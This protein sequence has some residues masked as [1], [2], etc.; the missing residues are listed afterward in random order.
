MRRQ[1]LPALRM[2]VVLTIAL[3]IG[4]PLVVLGVSQLAFHDKANGSLVT[5]ADGH[6]VGSSL[7]GQTFTGDR[8]FQGRPSA[9][10]ITASGSTD[11]DGQPGDPSDLSLS[12]S[13]GSNL[14]PTNPDLT[15]E[16]AQRAA[17]YRSLNGL[18]ADAPVPV[19]A[20]T[21]SGSGVDPQISVANARLQADRVARARGLDPATVLKLVDQHTDGRSLGVFG[22]PGVN[23]LELQPRPRRPGIAMPT[24]APPHPRTG[25]RFGAETA[26]R[27]PP[28][29][30]GRPGRVPEHPSP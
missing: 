14:G 5:A 11:A 17:D 29:R 20:V 4:Y 24:P 7:L 19:D 22:E 21:S 12:N 1:L 3:G 2:M 28:V 15:D 13:G 10:G 23:V 9:A 30:L 26:P 18:A 27:W 16:V 6:V 8:Y 25:S